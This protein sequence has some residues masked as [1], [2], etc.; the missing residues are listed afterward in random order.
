MEKTT[1]Q[2][3]RSGLRLGA[4]AGG[5]FIAAMLIGNGLGRILGSAGSHQIAWTDWIGWAELVLAVA[6]LLPTARV[7]LMLLGGYMVF[8]V[9][10]GLFLF[11]TASFPSHGFSTRVDPLELALYGVVTLALLYRF[12][13]SPPTVL[14]RVALIVFLFCF[15][16]PSSGLSSAL[17][18]SQM[19]GLAVLLVSWGVSRWRASEDPESKAHGVKAQ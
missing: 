13:E 10:K 15:V 11:A 7:W 1:K 6:I 18:W 14:D 16:M 19:I 8:G 3:V 2:Q 12:A 5:F 17:S 9:I 4:G